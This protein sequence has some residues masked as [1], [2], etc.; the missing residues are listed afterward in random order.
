M[1]ISWGS[2]A[3]KFQATCLPCCGYEPGT[4]AANYVASTHGAE[5]TYSALQSSYTP[6]GAAVC[7]G[8]PIF[9]MN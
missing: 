9:I 3:A 6:S 7:G 8:V 5:N 4:S 2:G 1:G